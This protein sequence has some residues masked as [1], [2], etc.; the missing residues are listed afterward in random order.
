MGAGI[1]KEFTNRGV[2]TRLLLN[3]VNHWNGRGYSLFTKID[4]FKGVY[5]LITKEKYYMKPTY[6]T[7]REALEDMKRQLPNDCNL[8]MPCIGSGLDKLEWTKVKEIIEDTFR[9]TDVT[10]TICKL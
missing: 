5:N 8:A 4:N 9:D 7:L 10:I 6:N 3:Y 2:K 1:A